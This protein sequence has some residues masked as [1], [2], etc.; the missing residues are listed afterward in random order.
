MP[1]QERY[2]TGYKGVY[3]IM[4]KQ[5]G[6]GKPERIYYIMYRKNGKQVHEKAGRA[7]KDDMSP[8]KASQLRVERMSAKGLSNQEK[9][10][11][12]EAQKRAEAGKWTID[13]L[14]KA[15]KED[16]KPGKSLNT[17]ASRY[18]LYLEQAF[19]DKEPSEIAPLDVDRLRINLGKQKSPQTVKH[20]LNLLNW[21]VNYGV[22]KG[23]CQGISFH[24]QKPTVDNQKT[25]DLNPE[26]LKKLITTLDKHHDRQAANF[27]KMALYTGMRRGELFRLQWQDVDFERGFIYIRGPKGGRDQKIPMN[28]SARELLKK[29]PKTK[30]KSPYVFPGRSGKKRTDIKKAVNKI[31]DDAGLPKDF[32]ALHGLRHVYAS[33]LASSGQVD[34]YTLQKL[35]THKNPIMTQRYAHL[36]DEALRNASNVAHDFFSNI[37]ADN[38]KDNSQKSQKAKKE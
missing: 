25:E 36:R 37:S 34:M 24:I 21:I 8:A 2:K 28:E 35:L 26:Q 27:M 19:G 30:H 14:W 1:K 38:K 5:A 16:R 18:T 20:V 31:K 11:L 23:L 12:E 6:T 13:K 4:G 10:E 9:R 15:Y 22:K 17:D 3:Y 7:K 32:R 33:M 29:H